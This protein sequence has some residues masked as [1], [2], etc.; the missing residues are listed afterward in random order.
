VGA[1]ATDEGTAAVGLVATPEE[2]EA[3]ALPESEDP[4]KA[5]G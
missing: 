4:E 3:E 1:V 2:T 5:K